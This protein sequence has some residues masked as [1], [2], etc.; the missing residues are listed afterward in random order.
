MNG[1]GRN[2]DTKNKKHSVLT[3][4]TLGVVLVLF[5]TLC[6]VCLITRDAVFSEPGKFINAFLLGCFGVFAYAVV[7]FL[8]ILGVLLIAGK[9]TGLSIK[10]K[11]L[12]TLSFVLIAILSHVISMRDF[13]GSYGEYLAKSYSMAEGGIATCSAGGLFTGLVAYVFPLLLSNVGSYVILGL[14]IVASVYFLVKEFISG[15]SEPERSRGKFRSS[16]VK[17]E[18]EKPEQPP[19]KIEGVKDYP[20]E[21]VVPV[22]VETPT[23][24]GKQKLFVNNPGDFALRSKRDIAKNKDTSYI[25]LGFSEHGLGVVSGASETTFDSADLKS[26]LDYI[27]TPPTIDVDKVNSTNY[28]TPI[29]SVTYS[30]HNPNNNYVNTTVS[31]YIQKSK[32]EETPV[33]DEIPHLEHDGGKIDLDD[34]KSRAE[35]FGNRYAMPSDFPSEPAQ[36]EVDKSS[37]RTVRDL[38]SAAENEV[39][40]VNDNPPFIEE[41]VGEPEIAEQVTAET[42]ESTIEPVNDQPPVSG[43]LSSDRVRSILFGDE[44]KSEEIAEAKTMPETPSNNDAFT[45]RVEADNNLGSR[46]RMFDEPAN[47]EEEKK[48]EKPAKPKPPINRK[49]HRPPFDLLETHCPP[50]DAPKEDHEGRMSIIQKTLAEVKIEVNPQSYVQG[51]SVTR[52]ELFLPDAA[53][54]SKVPSYADSLKMRLMV[55]DNIRIEAPI[56]GK[57]LIGVEVA[58]KVRIPVGL[59]EVMEGISKNNKGGSLVFALGKDVVGN[60]IGDD[61]AKGPHYLIA[62]ATGSGKSV[63]LHVMICSLLIRYSPEELKLVLVDPK[64]NEFNKYEHIPHLLVDEIITDTK[65]AVALL[66]WA[67]EE[68]TRRNEIF[69]ATG[70]MVSNIDEYNSIIANETTPKMPRIVFFIDELADLMESH[71][72]ELEEKI[73]RV[74]AK[75]RSAGI[76]LVL[77]TQR[78]SVDVVTGTIKTNLPSRIALKLMNFADSNTILSKGGAEKLLGNGDMLYQNSKMSDA[79]RYQGAYLSNREIMNI[80]NYIKEKNTGYFDDEVMSYLDQATKEEPE[81]TAITAEEGV[82]GK[83]DEL[84]LQALWLAVSTKTISISQLQ[85]RFQIGYARAGG[86]V[87]KMERSGFVSPNEGS[88][89]RRVLLDK[90]GFENR[91]GPA[92][93]TF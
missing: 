87:D 57:D 9:R 68:T 8:I 84:F 43:I 1:L 52:Y 93:D 51:P 65:R 46:R 66:H 73:R 49:Y 29:K 28:N 54:L 72:K 22:A 2:R 13:T 36:S 83:E 7:I 55:E 59:K 70:G 76:H 21:N 23:V 33:A 24:S 48:E 67:Y 50:V 17:K 4:E 80:V 62:G 38:E 79:V 3:S 61:L 77:A 27:K 58:N 37:F 12:L 35:V 63:C 82:G 5:A 74:A 92:P 69:A 40:E 25:K 39:V 56:P 53:H 64:L 32:V 14:C 30:L 15:Y 75:S 88:K 60:A 18:E 85:R 10:K 42:Q 6:T 16:F 81:E 86:L 26:K 47:K 34:A 19:V 44:E 89:A 90:E 41:S 71:K 78:P 45:S 31:D 91:F 20:V 11:T